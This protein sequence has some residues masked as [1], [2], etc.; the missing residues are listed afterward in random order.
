MLTGRIYLLLAG[1]CPRVV[2]CPPLIYIVFIKLELQ[3]WKKKVFFKW[4]LLSKKKCL[5]ITVFFTCTLLTF[6]F[7][8]FIIY[9]FNLLLSTT[10]W[11]LLLWNYISK[12]R[13]NCLKIKEKQ[14]ECHEQLKLSWVE[15]LQ[16]LLHLEMLLPSQV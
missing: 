14:V 15:I 13:K 6:E 10:V 1:S 16:T 4:V 12:K 3:Y 7:K 8:Q 11:I 9:K 2:R 5:C